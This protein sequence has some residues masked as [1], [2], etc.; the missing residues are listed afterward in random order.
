MIVGACTLHLYLPGV[1]SLK[2]KR[3][4]L[5]PLLTQVRRRFEVAAAE[6]DHHDVWQTSDI[7]IVAVANEPGHVYSVLEKTVRWVEDNVY[8]VQVMDWDTELR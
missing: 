5:K 1:A 2:E 8:Q 3:S 6:V 7:A 4:I